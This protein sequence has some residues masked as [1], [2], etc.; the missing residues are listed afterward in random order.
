VETTRIRIPGA[1]RGTWAGSARAMPVALFNSD[2]GVFVMAAKQ[3][4]T[5]WLD[6]QRDLVYDATSPCEGPSSYHP[7]TANAYIFPS[8]RCSYYLLGMSFRPYADERY[9]DLSLGSRFGYIIAHELAHNNLNTPYVSPGIDTLTARYTAASTRNEAFADILGS[10]GVIDAGHNRSDV[11]M[12]ISQAWCARV[13]PGYYSTT[14]HSH[15]LAN[16]RGDYLCQTLV[17]L[18]L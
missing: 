7:L 4:R 5:I 11:C 13:P 2:D 15:P 1:P 16:R 17:D 3:A 12:H 9:N 14:G 8:Y 10:M 6:R 18:G